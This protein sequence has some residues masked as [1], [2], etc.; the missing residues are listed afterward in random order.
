MAYKKSTA[1][2]DDLIDIYIYGHVNFSEAQAE[3]YFYELESVFEFLGDNPLVAREQLVGN[4]L[5]R[6]HPHASH[7]IIYQQTNY[8]ILIIRVLHK[9]MLSALHL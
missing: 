3:K 5:L 9:S 1:T 8:G 4:Q 2:D 6:I 7:Q